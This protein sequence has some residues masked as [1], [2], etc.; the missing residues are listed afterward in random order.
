MAKPLRTLAWAET[1]ASGGRSRG[2][3]VEREEDEA[4]SRGP[5]SATP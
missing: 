2:R 4:D 1:P 3:A 5:L